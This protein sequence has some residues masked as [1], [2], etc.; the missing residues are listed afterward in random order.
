[1]ALSVR[2]IGVGTIERRVRCARRPKRTTVVAP[3]NITS[4]NGL[5]MLARITYVEL[6]AELDLEMEF[7]M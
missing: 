1:M 5:L 4:G 7:V 6:V 2:D 3:A